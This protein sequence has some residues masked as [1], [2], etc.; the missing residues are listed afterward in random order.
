MIIDNFNYKTILPTLRATG[1]PLCAIQHELVFTINDVVLHYMAADHYLTNIKTFNAEIFSI[2][3]INKM[4]FCRNVYGY[5]PMA[6]DF[7]ECRVNATE[8]IYNIT[9]ALF[10]ACVAVNVPV[11]KIELTSITTDFLKGVPKED[12][13]KPKIKGSKVKHKFIDVDFPDI[14]F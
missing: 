3:G 2:L 8:C 9:E 12:N 4:D 10:D 1:K 11:E 6:C 13:S 14:P 5:E 7:P